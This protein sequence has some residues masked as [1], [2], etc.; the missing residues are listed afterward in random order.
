M[1]RLTHLTHA[2]VDTIPETLDH[3][4]LYVSIDPVRD[5]PAPV[6]MRLRP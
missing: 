1:T 4:V 5:G 6:C 2:F 3:G